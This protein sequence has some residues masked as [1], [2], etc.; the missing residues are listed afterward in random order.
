MG[1][2]KAGQLLP[3]LEDLAS[4]NG[5][6]IIAYLRSRCP[7]SATLTTVGAG[8]DSPYTNCQDWGRAVLGELE[9]GPAPDVLITAARPVVGVPDHPRPDATSFRAIARGMGTYWEA[10]EARGTEVV[11]VR[12]TPEMGVDIPDCLSAPGATIADCSRSQADAL[13]ASP[14]TVQ[15]TQANEDVPLVDLTPYLCPDGNCSPVLGDV[16]VYRDAHHLT[17]TYTLSLAPYLGAALADAGVVDTV[18]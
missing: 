3:A 13:P 4:R 18:K 1:D 12:E 10:M 15:A 7:W 8:D 2:S 16:V 6:H 11:A 14:P 17:R 9:D 5:W